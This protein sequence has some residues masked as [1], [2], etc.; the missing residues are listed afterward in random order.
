MLDL[1]VD[2]NGRLS[3]TD[4]QELPLSVGHLA[5]CSPLP[6]YVTDNYLAATLSKYD[7]LDREKKKEKMLK[8]RR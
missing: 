6:M 2:E 8:W 4:F 1:F 5:Y 3:R 7:K